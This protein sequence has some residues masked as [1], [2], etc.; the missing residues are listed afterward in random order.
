MAVTGIPPA[1]QAWALNE[2]PTVRF[3]QRM[4]HAEVRILPCD[5]NNL[6]IGGINKAPAARADRGRPTG[7]HP[8][9]IR[10]RT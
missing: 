6:R 2:L 1:I 7:D 4:E 8:E 5:L 3:W 9:I 10:I